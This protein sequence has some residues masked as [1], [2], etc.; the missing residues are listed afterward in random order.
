VPNLRILIS[1]LVA[2]FR[3][4]RLEQE[5]DEEVRSHL[6]MLVEENVRKGMSSEEARYAALRSFGGVE[7]V[8]EIYRE[9]RG[10][11]V[12][13]TLFQD[14]RYGLRMLAKNPG[15][16][17][18]A[19]VTLALGIG[20]NT[21]IFS[22]I[23]AFM[24]RMIPVKSPD[25]LVLL[26]L[27]ERPGAG[28]SFSYPAYQRFQELKQD[29]AGILACTEG[30]F[31]L[32][33]IV[34][35]KESSGAVEQVGGEGVSGNYFSVLG[36]Q[37]ALGRPFTAADDRPPEGQPVTIISYDFWKRRFGLDPTVVGRNIALNGIP[38]TIIGI[39]PPRFEGIVV[40]EKPDLWWP[41]YTAPRLLGGWNPFSDP[42]N[43]W[44]VLIGRLQPGANALHARAGLNVELRQVLN[45]ILKQWGASMTPKE[46]QNFLSRQVE[47]EPGATGVSWLR[48]KFT[49]PLLVLMAAVGL[50][51]LIACS[52]VA[53]LLLARASARQRETAVRLA[54]GAGR[55]RLIR[56]L[57]TESVLLALMGGTLGLLLAYWGGA[58]LVAF[59][60]GRQGSLALNV[61][62]DPGV[63]GFTFAA[64]VLTGMLF[65]MAPA[66]RATRVD[67]TPA[68]KGITGAVQVGRSRLTLGKALVVSQVVLSVLL[69]V[70]AGL[71]VRT[72]E[73]LRGVHEGFDQDNLLLF[74]LDSVNHYTPRQT[75]ELYQ[76]LLERLRT[77]PGTRSVSYSQFS[78]MSGSI[79]K[80]K[81]TAEGYTSALNE[82]LSCYR[83]EVGP[84][85]FE[86]MG[87][88][89]LL[90]RDFTDRD[91]V[92]VERTITID[93]K[94]GE[95]IPPPEGKTIH[96]LAVINEAM[97]HYF[98]GSRDPIGRHFG[99]PETTQ[100]QFDIVGVV[101]DAKY[102]NLRDGP[103]RT[104][105]LLES[106]RGFKPLEIR[107][108]AKASTVA[109]TLSKVVREIDPTLLIRNV[110]TMQ[111]AVDDTLIQERFTAQLSGFFS[112]FALSLAC[113]GLYGVLAYGVTRRTTEIGIR[114]ALGAD[115][116]KV[117]W[118]ILREGLELVLL[119]VVLGIPLGLAAARLLSSMLFGL[120][121]SDPVTLLAAALAMMAVATI[122]SYVPGRKASQV[123]PI[124]A[125]HYE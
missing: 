8:K 27:V 74:S 5:L 6:E 52:N 108:F 54:L 83:L 81:V 120:K 87:I 112:L 45:E 66:L 90:G 36:V 73:K 37:P 38:F 75:Q 110:R 16:T 62:P 125:L 14:A 58:F 70:G 11:P 92:D 114:L 35:G 40:G 39:A 98:F 84:R 60:G 26:S 48:E 68:L 61:S 55:A 72:L 67:L 56:Q 59:M 111:D 123:D 93:E 4:Q 116:H 43:W 12:I 89:V 102:S 100:L 32:K 17:T 13:E 57:L 50:V 88:P 104:F 97:A 99:S 109:G 33:M 65:G 118:M 3:K 30:A 10:L 46:R 49:R 23:N 42:D 91:L 29:F 101:K 78:L 20:A 22:V 53:N 21:A 82:D 107:T 19:V 24:L 28:Y 103:L 122:A 51:L 69:L 76:R 63:L 18:V 96:L 41:L 121:P 117:L 7:Q 47:L 25:Q 1:R 44:L 34:S 94:T 15:F 86:T 95:Q 9:Q 79:E 77:L 115:R 31:G 80:S 124:V 106:P 2:L 85:F 71:L 113:I 119:G 105:Y 64:S